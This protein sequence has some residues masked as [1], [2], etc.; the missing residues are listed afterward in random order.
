MKNGIS[1]F[2]KKCGTRFIASTYVS[3]RISDGR[4]PAAQPVVQAERDHPPERLAM[5]REQLGQ[6]IPVARLEAI[7]Q[8]LNLVALIDH[9]CAIPGHPRKRPLLRKREDT[10][11]SD[12]PTL[13]F[14]RGHAPVGR[15]SRRQPQEE[16][17]Q[18]D[19][20]RNEAQGVDCLE[21]HE[22]RD[23]GQDDA[24]LKRRN[25]KCKP[26]VPVELVPALRL[27]RFGLV[28]QLDL[29]RFVAAGLGAEL[30]DGRMASAPAALPHRRI[31]I[32]APTS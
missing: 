1:G 28:F 31:T 16:A 19:G 27:D 21:P 9:R 10:H 15:G 2:S 24:H 30:V 20:T 22:Q 8:P 6:R 5:P 25:R 3:C 7:Q 14:P 4:D 12:A 17:D 13:I 26:L 23:R 29:L 11:A 32:S 18:A